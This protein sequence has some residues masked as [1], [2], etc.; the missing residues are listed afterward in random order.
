MAEMFV[1][2]YGVQPAEQDRLERELSGIFGAPAET[3]A[4]LGGV[5]D[6]VSFI[7]ELASTNLKEAAQQLVALVRRS[8][9]M[10]I[11]ISVKGVSITVDG[12]TSPEQVMPLLQLALGAGM[13]PSPGT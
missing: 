11:E 5:G 7:V 2:V 1:A 8:V 3:E 13:Q 9:G 10:R 4:T 6:A 12:A